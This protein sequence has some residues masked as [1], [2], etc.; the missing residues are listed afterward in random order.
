MGLGFKKFKRRLLLSALVKCIAACLGAAA[1]AAAVVTAVLRLADVSAAVSPILLYLICCLGCGAVAFLACG[2]ILYPTNKRTARRLDRVL[3]LGEMM[4][5]MLEYRGD[6]GFVAVLQREDADRRLRESPL[7]AVRTAGKRIIAFAVTLAI[8]A[9]LL[10][11]SLLIP[12]AADNSDPTGGTEE[13]TVDEANKQRIINILNDIAY[14]LE[15]PSNEKSPYFDDSLQI[16]QIDITEMDEALRESA[17]ARLRALA[18]EIADMDK[19]SAMKRAAV[20]MVQATSSDYLTKNTYS[21][22]GGAF[23]ASGVALVTDFGNRLSELNRRASS[24]ALE[25][26]VSDAQSLIADGNTSGA[27]VYADEIAAALNASGAGYEDPLRSC[28]SVLEAAIRSAVKS[29]DASSLSAASSTAKTAVRN[30]V[31]QQSYNAGVIPNVV[32]MVMQLF[33]I[34]EEDLA[35]LPSELPD[36]FIPDPPPTDGDDS[37]NPEKPDDTEDNN[38]SS[39]GDGEVDYASKDL[40]YWPPEKKYLP[41]AEVLTKVEAA[42]SDEMNGKDIDPELKKAVND[43]LAS[44]QSK[45]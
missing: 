11:G 35:E 22:I 24:D 1:L 6:D 4:Q 29:G 27:I 8:C 39:V 43:F 41:Y 15:N 3:E 33:A 42:L 34:T 23:S 17:I 28:L 30:A 25:S 20:A 37:T 9:G 12:V 10:V 31:D 38:N 36:E 26:M 2:V 13:P 7:S 14:R 32:K 19:L 18:T 5:T 16:R 21:A 40:V 44:L 45:S